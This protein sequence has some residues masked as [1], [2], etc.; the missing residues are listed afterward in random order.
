[1][2]RITVN[3]VCRSCD[4]VSVTGDIDSDRP[5]VPRGPISQIL[6]DHHKGTRIS[7]PRTNYYRPGHHMYDVFALT[8]PDKKIGSIEFHEDG[9]WYTPSSER[10]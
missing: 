7:D 1:M 5:R 2:P 4:E 9:G 10:K 6:L 3:V 8:N